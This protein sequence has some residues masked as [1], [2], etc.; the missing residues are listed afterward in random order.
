MDACERGEGLVW[1]DVGGGV[2]LGS[3][4]VVVMLGPV[5]ERGAVVVLVAVVTWWY[6]VWY[7]GWSGLFVRIVVGRE[8][9][10]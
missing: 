1:M 2:R 4:W 3:V 8:L 10:R 7:M 5:S 6:M 9:L